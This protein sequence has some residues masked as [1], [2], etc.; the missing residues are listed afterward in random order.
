MTLSFIQPFEKRFLEEY[1][2][3]NRIH[4]R[5]SLLLAVA[6]Y[7]VFGFLDAALLSEFRDTFWFI[8]FGIFAPFSLIVLLFSFSSNF[9][10]YYQY[11]CSA[12]VLLA[13]L[14][15]IVMI[16]IATDKVSYTYYA[17]LILVFIFGY[18]FCRIRFIYATSTALL[19]VVAY[20]I[21]A[22]F[23]STTPL[24]VLISNNFFFLTGNILGMFAGYSIE[25]HVRREYY[26][27]HLLE[28]EK[29][30]VKIANIELEDRVTQ[31]TDQLNRAILELRQEIIERKKSE[32]ACRQGEEKYRAILEG[33]EEGYYEVDLSGEI[34]FHN[35]S[36]SKIISP[37]DASL[38]GRSFKEFTDLQ[39]AKK[40][41]RVFGQ[42]FKT[43]NPVKGMDFRILNDGVTEKIISLSAGLIK[44]ESG[45]V[46]GFRG[47]IRDVTERILAEEEIHRLNN[48]LEKRVN[49]RT[50]QLNNANTA[51]RKSLESLKETQD[52]L[53]QNEKMAALGG[54]VA[55]IAH[56]INTPVGIGVTA[57]SLMEEKTNA[58]MQLHQS[59]KMKRSQFEDYLQVASDTTNAILSNLFRAAD[60]IRNF[61]QVAVDQSS[62]EKRRFNLK[63]YIES[64]LI[65][66]RPKLKNKNYSIQTYCPEDL[67][68]FSYPGIISQI[69]TNL[70]MNSLIHGFEQEPDGTI[71]IEAEMRGDQLWLRYGDNGKGMDSETL[72]KIYNPFFSTKRTKDGTGLGLHIVFNLIS[73]TLKGTIACQSSPGAGTVFEITI[74]ITLERTYVS[75]IA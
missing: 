51:L 55:G 12:V 18:T 21:S 35:D 34:R 66:L 6:I 16:V 13:G 27:T 50:L 30:K 54:L 48:S 47:I 3:K 68:I 58:I 19:I 46:T 36:T 7:S 74:P 72:K 40:F 5:L 39:T 64:I 71:N 60:L 41:V 8:R 67:E 2:I 56:E 32:M 23:I 70:I 65:S 33:I 75:E 1:Y 22:I 45:E 25:L 24:N 53:V 14:G 61:K 10:K 15:I 52:H 38:T 59:G 29:Q 43:G 20:E 62:E 11:L 73:Q 49:E 37:G 63:E 57:A 9:I 31:R 42:I 44:N 26:Q 17:G 4:I 28:E 69:F